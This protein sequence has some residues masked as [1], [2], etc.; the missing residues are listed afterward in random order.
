V[1]GPLIAGI[2]WIITGLVLMVA[3][4]LSTDISEE[5]IQENDYI[6]V[7]LVVL[8]PVLL[9]GWT[10]YGLKTVFTMVFGHE[11]EVES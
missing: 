7:A 3:T 5:D 10:L 8:W 11:E 2:A 9:L 4:I 6:F 1:S